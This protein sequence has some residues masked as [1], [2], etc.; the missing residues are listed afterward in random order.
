MKHIQTITV[1]AGGAAEIEFSS[2]PQTYTDLILKV[3]VRG[4]STSFGMLLK[5]NG[6]TT[7]ISTRNLEGSGSSVS[8]YTST[9]IVGYLVPSSATANTFGNTEIYIS[10]YTGAT[11]KSVS[12]DSVNEN[13]GTTAYSVLTAWLWSNTS[14][15]TSLS[16]ACEAGSGNTFAQYSSASLYGIKNS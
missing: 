2:I 11:Y 6:A 5:P 15:I 14:A 10:N 8:S 3:S 16:L 12:A 7:S 4:T 13:N 1:G 9:N